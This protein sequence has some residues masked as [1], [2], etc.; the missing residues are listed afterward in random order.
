MEGYPLMAMLVELLVD[1]ISDSI[2]SPKC[3]YFPPIPLIR[4]TLITFEWFFTGVH[5]WMSDT[6]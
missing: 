5:A 4:K 2:K 3:Y 1:V 6:H